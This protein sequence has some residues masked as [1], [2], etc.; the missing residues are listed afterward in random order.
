[1]VLYQWPLLLFN[2][3]FVKTNK[4]T[5]VVVFVHRV[6]KQRGNCPEQDRREK[7]VIANIED[8]REH[9]ESETHQYLYPDLN[10]TGHSICCQRAEKNAG[11]RGDKHPAKILRA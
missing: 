7:Q 1:M 3:Y 4:L 2:T 9:Q 8:A 6:E 10:T 11:D 5:I